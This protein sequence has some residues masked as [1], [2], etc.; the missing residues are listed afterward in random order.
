[1][2]PA[3][4]RLLGLGLVLALTAGWSPVP[5]A[6][7]A[8]PPASIAVRPDCGP[9]GVGPPPT[10]APPPPRSLTVA[11]PTY[12]IEVIGRGMPPNDQADVIFNPGGQQQAFAGS[13][14]EGGA[15][16]VVIHPITVPAGTYVV[17]VRPYTTT[18]L[19]AL[20]GPP[21]STMFLVPCPPP[22]P[23]A[24]S[25]VASPSVPQRTGPPPRVLNPTLTLTPAVGPPGT[26]VVA[27]GAEFP[28][29]VP[30]QLG[31]NQ[32]IA[33]TTLAP[34]TT[35]ASGAFT[36]TVL[37]LPHDELGTRVLTAVSAPPINS[38]LFGFASAFFLVVPGEVQPSSFSW[39]R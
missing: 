19:F 27:R 32:G 25:P 18:G 2:T 15:I 11:A 8:A 22:P 35:D 28:P 16:D 23:P 34:V 6:A 38:A 39:R 17:Q 21:V 24:P 33:G 7:A 1:M 5:A 3:R 30:V 4:R 31:W 37:I 12:A 13:T 36:T 20:P 26:I 29:M 9:V 10:S 14:D